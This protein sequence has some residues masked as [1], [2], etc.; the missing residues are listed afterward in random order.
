[1]TGTSSQNPGPGQHSPSNGGDLPPPYAE[2]TDPPKTEEKDASTHEKPRSEGAAGG[3]TPSKS[4]AELRPPQTARYLLGLEDDS[5]ILRQAVGGHPPISPG[6][7]EFELVCLRCWEYESECTCQ[8]KWGKKSGK[9]TVAIRPSSLSATKKP[10]GQLPVPIRLV[11][12]IGM[13]SAHLA[14]G[15]AHSIW[16]VTCLGQIPV[17]SEDSLSI[18]RSRALERAPDAKTFLKKVYPVAPLPEGTECACGCQETMCAQVALHHGLYNSSE[19]LARASTTSYT[20]EGRPGCDITMV[21]LGNGK[22]YIPSNNPYIAVTEI[23][24]AFE[25]DF[26]LCRAISHR[27]FNATNAAPVDRTK[28]LTWDGILSNLF[29]A[30]LTRTTYPY[31]GFLDMSLRQCVSTGVGARLVVRSEN[32]GVGTGHLVMDIGPGT[33]VSKTGY[34]TEG[35][36][37]MRSNAYLDIINLSHPQSRSTGAGSMREKFSGD[38]RVTIRDGWSQVKVDVSPEY[39][40]FRM[41]SEVDSN[42]MGYG[43]LPPARPSMG[44]RCSGL[45]AIQKAEAVDYAG[46]APPREEGKETTV[47]NLG[48][49][50]VPYMVVAQYAQVRER[51]L[52]FVN[53]DECMECT[54]LHAPSGS[55]VAGPLPKVSLV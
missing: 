6:P 4:S 22:T 35:R 37:S 45:C 47:Y 43:F 12:R 50:A 11:K 44:R 55:I 10:Y 1:M 48:K 18:L 20:V 23:E 3:V 16:P 19:D 27:M 31:I 36:I 53:Y 15:V 39:P 33:K 38:A 32:F 13:R 17:F 28:M 30:V 5:E 25:E 8:S 21:R 29:E 24:S 49:D 7:F 41:T 52:Y 46:F 34:E 40:V 54:I 42:R 14:T 51:P 26:L 2:R 9:P